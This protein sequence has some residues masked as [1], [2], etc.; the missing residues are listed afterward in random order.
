MLETL[1]VAVFFVFYWLAANYSITW[2]SLGRFSRPARDAII[3][4]QGQAPYCAILGCV[5]NPLG[6][7]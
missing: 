3:H 4:W 7:R 6:L 2:L 5:R 1:G